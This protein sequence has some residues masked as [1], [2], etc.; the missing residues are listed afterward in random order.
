[1]KI[2]I[3]IVGH[4]K[5][6]KIILENILLNKHFNLLI[7]ITKQKVLKKN[8]SKKT[9]VIS[10]YK[11]ITK[12]KNVK[13]AFIATSPDKQIKISQ[14]F[15]KN[16]ISLILE[17]PISTN[18][19][20]INK[21][22]KINKIYKKLIIVN[23]IYLHHPLI[24]HL[25]NK[26]LRSKE[27]IINI[28]TIGGDN[29]PERKY[30]S[31]LF[32]WGPHDLSILLFFIKNPTINNINFEKRFRRINYEINFQSKEK[33]ISSI[34][35]GNNF[36]SKTRKIKIFNNKNFYE[37]NLISNNIFDQNNKKLKVKIVDSPLQNVLN[38]FYNNFKNKKII[39]RDLIFSKILTNILLKVHK[40]TV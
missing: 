2:D 10:D 9:I 4:G 37:L 22:I 18:I 36:K 34:C 17:K 7:L 20:S 25:Q 31:T 21:L 14:F 3:C 12:F 27:K 1:M 33:F 23:Y 40:K 29:K 6:G 11:K 8:I 28:E 24:L 26:L 13:A 30:I 19:H 35:F 15:L 39:N 5:W 32:D 16:N 38:Y